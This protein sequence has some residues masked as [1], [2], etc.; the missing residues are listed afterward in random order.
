MILDSSAIVAVV[1]R[2]TNSN[3]LGLIGKLEVASA[4]GVGAPTLAEASLVLR[5][6]LGIDPLPILDRFL[7]AFDVTVVD[8]KEQH[9]RE[10]A[11]A[12][13]RYGKGRHPAALNFGDCMTYAVAR[14]AA[15]PLL[16]VGEDFAKTDLSSA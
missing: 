4:I 16:F 2:E 13:G 5:A 9:W 8:F 6:H 7:R 15:A 1:R 3:Y 12:F 14:L 10:A 11:D